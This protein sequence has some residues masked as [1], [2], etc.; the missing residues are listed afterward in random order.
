MKGKKL[1]LTL[2]I[3]LPLEQVYRLKGRRKEELKGGEYGKGLTGEIFTAII[4]PEN[5]M[6]E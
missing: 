1:S 5:P 4:L 2:L 6:R 3:Y